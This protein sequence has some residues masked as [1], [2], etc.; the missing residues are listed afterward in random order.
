MDH[1]LETPPSADAIFLTTEVGAEYDAR[2]LMTGDV[3]EMPDGTLVVLVQHPCAMRSG[4]GLLPRLLACEVD[5]AA[6][7][8]RSKWH[9]ERFSRMRLEFLGSSAVIDFNRPLVL[10][11]SAAHKM[12]RV[13]IMD[14]LGVNLLLQRWVHHNSRVVI[15]TVTYD[16]QSTGPYA[17]VDLV[18]DMVTDLLAEG[19]DEKVAE[20]C[21]EHFFSRGLEGGKS[22]CWRHRLAQ[23]QQQ[24]PARRAADA[25]VQ[26]V[27]ET[28]DLQEEGLPLD[29]S[30]LLSRATA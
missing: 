21:V 27:I 26:R 16:R 24:G 23:A 5:L 4:Q 7:D 19:L 18:Q 8:V 9:K 25:F 10:E 2:P 30:D 13:A 15:K 29:L 3:I 6:K 11:T 28:V 22:D 12:H 17:E 1:D 14:R 20:D